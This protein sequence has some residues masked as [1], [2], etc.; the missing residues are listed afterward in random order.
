MR[1]GTPSP[2]RSTLLEAIHG[3]TSLFR[4]ASP[5][6]AAT[7]SLVHPAS[8]LV[9]DT[10][11]SGPTVPGPAPRRY[12][13]QEQRGRDRD[14]GASTGVRHACPFHGIRTQ[15]LPIPRPSSLPRPASTD[16]F[17]TGRVAH[18]WLTAEPWSCGLAHRAGA[19]SKHHALSPFLPQALSH[20][21]SQARRAA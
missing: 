4:K 14:D 6:W 19:G 16:L 2:L 5:L 1:S 15:P 10:L 17:R 8:G 11:S 3:S 21:H 20:L 18:S 12:G 9:P 7:L 13:E